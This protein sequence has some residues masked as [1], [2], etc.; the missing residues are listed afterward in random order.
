MSVYHSEGVTARTVRHAGLWQVR[1]RVENN[2]ISRDQITK[3]KKTPRLH[4]RQYF[5]LKYEFYSQLGRRKEEIC[6]TN[7]I[8]S[9][10]LKEADLVL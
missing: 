4:R 3:N 6:I 8:N 2:L 1:S 10:R 5:V 7:N 9:N